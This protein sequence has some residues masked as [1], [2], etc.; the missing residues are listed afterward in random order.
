MK[1][2]LGTPYFSIACNVYNE[3][4]GAYLQDA[5]SRGER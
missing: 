5:G 1:T 4:L 2:P 3:Q